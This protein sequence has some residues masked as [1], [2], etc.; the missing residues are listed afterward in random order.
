MASIHRKEGSK[1]WYCCYSLPSG[2]RVYCSTA[3]ANRAEAMREACKIEAREL[4]K[5]KESSA[6]QRT[7]LDQVKEAATL[8]KRG[9]LSL[10]RA[11]EIMGRIVAAATGKEMR[12][13]TVREWGNEWLAGKSG[14]AA[15]SSLAVYAGFMRGFL[16]FIGPL[17]DG[18]IEHLNESSFR[19]YRDDLRNRKRTGKTC[20]QA[21]KILRGWMRAAVN[22][23]HLARN[24]AASVP[25]L[26]E[27]DSIERAP[28]EGEELERMLTTATG[29]WQGVVMLGMYGGMRLRDATN[30]RWSSVDMDGAVIRFRPLKTARRK[31]EI[32]LPIHPS[33]EVYLKTLPLPLHPSNFLFSDLAGRS[34]GGPSGL[35]F[36][37]NAILAKAKI[38]RDRVRVE[39]DG[40][41]VVVGRL[42]FHSLRHTFASMLA[43]GG[44]SE[45]L[46]MELAG[47]KTLEMARH[48]THH[49][50][51]TLRKAVGTLPDFR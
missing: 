16:S 41:R 48:Y 44:V 7:V 4:A 1:N 20:N 5:A 33:L 24:P 2:K 28:F 37:F 31:S 23:G 26:L 15:K 22:Q 35:S 34:T 40:K 50:L 18:P 30:L 51:E 3:T 25:M 12:F 6:P 13:Y 45:G 9:D 27:T 10:D 47:H 19:E 39:S 11:R 38:E 43:K 29:S 8:A 42:T 49:E 36:E 46:R 32:V 21:L 14:S 17:A